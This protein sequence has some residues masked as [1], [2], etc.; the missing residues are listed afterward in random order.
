MK[1][2]LNKGVYLVIDPSQDNRTLLDTLKKLLNEGIVAVQLYDN[3]K[4]DLIQYKDFI[5]EIVSL[6]RPKDVPVIINNKWQWLEACDLDGVHFDH[7]PSTDVPLN[8][9]TEEKIIGLTCGNNLQSVEWAEKHQI[10]Y[11]SF[12]SIFPS[13]TAK[14]CEIVTFE[15]VKAAQAIT[16]MPIFLAGGIKPENIT[17]LKNLEFTGI[18]V[19]SGIMSAEEPQE[20]LK[21]YKRKLNIK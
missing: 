18:A 2:K 7:P 14:E 3:F 4:S 9:F 20:A 10:D 5:H 1:K 13:D 15:T 6:C 19:V 16:T 12:C 8:F 21:T 11:I 17:H